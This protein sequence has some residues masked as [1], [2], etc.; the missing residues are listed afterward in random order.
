MKK[1]LKIRS[2][3]AYLLSLSLV[4]A[5]TSCEDKE[6]VEDRPELPPI[7]S[8][9]MDFSDFAEEPGGDKGTLA[10]Y[11]NFWYSFWTVAIWNSAAVIV[12]ALPVTAYAYALQQTPAYVGNY[13][14]E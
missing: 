2:I 7:E 8:L 3:A 11:Q 9:K 14:W 10:T 6:P 4:F 12:S 13:T 5:A 1:Y